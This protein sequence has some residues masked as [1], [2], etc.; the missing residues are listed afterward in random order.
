MEDTVDLLLLA[1][2]WWIVGFSGAMM[3]GPVTT[4]VVTESARRGFI[5][6]PLITLGHVLLEL[7]MVFALVLGLDGFLKQT[8]ILGA[9]GVGGGVMLAW[10]GYGIIRSAWLK[11]VSFDVTRP[12]TRGVGSGNPILAGVL[13]SVSNP[14]WLFWWA[15]VGAASLITFR[16]FGWA[17]ILAFYIGHTLADWVWNSTLALAVATGRRIMTDGM[18][19]GV[20]LVCGAF[21]L[22]LSFY[23]VSSGIGFLRS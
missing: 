11:Q 9:I 22:V 8:P 13:T 16:A 12:D 17:G 7:A 3:P 1:G 20:L 10:M 18:Y 6:A 4:L 15:T 23:F 21:L 19:R 2:T 5:A 14:Y